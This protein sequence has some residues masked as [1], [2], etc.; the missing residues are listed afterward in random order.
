MYVC[1]LVLNLPC[2]CLLA[3]SLI[4]PFLWATS[5]QRSH[6]CQGMLDGFAQHPEN[7][8]GLTTKPGDPADAD[9][10]TFPVKTGPAGG[11]GIHAQIW[12]R[13]KDCSRRSP[14]TRFRE[15]DK[16]YGLQIFEGLGTPY[17][18]Q[19]FVLDTHNMYLQLLMTRHDASKVLRS[20]PQ[21]PPILLSSL[22]PSPPIFISHPDD[23][24]PVSIQSSHSG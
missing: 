16:N 5:G 9:L 14:L 12:A 4:P 21:T 20:T 23:V 3:W 1:A 2:H 15:M 19:A 24:S 8:V 10:F 22:P 11:S 6:I 17:Y 18:H 7:Y 13:E